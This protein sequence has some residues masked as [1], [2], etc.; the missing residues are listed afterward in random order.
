MRRL[1]P[2][3]LGCALAIAG[4]GH[5]ARTTTVTARTPAATPTTATAPTRLESC[6]EEERAIQRQ[7]RGIER[8]NREVRE[9]T[10]A[11]KALPLQIEKLCL[12]PERHPPR[13]ETLAVAEGQLAAGQVRSALV[14]KRYRRLHLT[15]DTG[16]SAAIEYGRHQEAVVVA[17]LR[18]AGVPITIE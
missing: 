15:L 10:V 16:Q 4:C 17:E 1:G 7:N 9:G 12:P 3:L 18:Q 2:G 8:H 11:G 14:V 6:R 13:F 5:S